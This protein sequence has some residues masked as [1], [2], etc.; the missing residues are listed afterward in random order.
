ML[1][2]C[3]KG[4]N[5]M[6]DSKTDREQIDDLF[7]RWRAAGRASDVEELVGLVTEDAEFWTP[8]VP[9]LKGREAV[10]AG[11]SPAFAQFEVDQDF[12]RQELVVS[13]D[14]AFARGLEI[15]RVT[16]RVGGTEIVR[17]QRAFMVMKR[18]DDGQ[19]RFA[20]GMTH[21]PPEGE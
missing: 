10:R 13:G 16:P 4:S 17:R 11:F 20:R 12:Q 9:P 15:N 7:D 5:N 2:G 21:L 8:G 3:E 14:W 6:A 1:R 18:G 19:W